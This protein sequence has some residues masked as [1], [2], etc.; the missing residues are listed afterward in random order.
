MFEALD[1]IPEP[2]MHTYKK[3]RRRISKRVEKN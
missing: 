3:K 2:H 1:P